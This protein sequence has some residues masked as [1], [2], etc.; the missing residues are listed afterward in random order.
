MPATTASRSSR[1][2]L[3]GDEE[4]LYRA[5]QTRLLHLVGKD[6]TAPREVI[7]DACAHAWAELLARQPERTSIAGWLWVVAQREA[8]RLAQ[9]DRRSVPIGTV[10]SDRL[11]GASRSTCCSPAEAALHCRALEALDALA[12]LS[13]RK[14]TFL[15]LKVAGY[16][17]HEITAKLGVSYRTVDRQL[18]RARRAAR[19]GQRKAPPVSGRS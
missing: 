12:G 2:P 16:S 11:C 13:L 4:D 14:R 15:A 1:V 18:V 9:H 10:G 8:I 19:I 17:Y 3:R 6:V 5:H 7:E